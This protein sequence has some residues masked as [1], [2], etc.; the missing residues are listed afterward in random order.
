MK[1]LSIMFGILAAMSCPLGAKEKASLPKEVPFKLAETEKKEGAA[2]KP[3]KALHSISGQIVAASKS[4]VAFKAAGNVQKIVAKPGDTVKKGELLATLDPTDY[5]IQVSL[6][7]A[8]KQ[9]AELQEELA[10][11]EFKREKQLKDEGASSG[12]QFDQVEF[13]YKQAK[14]SHELAGLNLKMAQ[15]NLE[16]TKLR[17]PYNCVVAIQYKDQA[18]RVSP[19]T[20][21][22]DLY[23]ASNNEVQLNAP[24]LLVGKLSVGTKLTIQIPSVSYR[25]EAT[26]T[27]VV[28]VIMEHTRTFRVTAKL[29]NQDARVVP[30]LFAEAQMN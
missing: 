4:T 2:L 14:L 29:K 28:P 25:D 21:A 10:N 30:G 15:R 12:S 20:P 16:N 7:R 18:E 23:E 26:V 19:E 27:R 22:F 13:K 1:K 17:A 6:A 9:Q 24:E 8:N 5:E 11:T 3:S